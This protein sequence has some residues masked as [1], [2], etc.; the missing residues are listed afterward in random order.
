MTEEL[1]DMMKTTLY[2]RRVDG[3]VKVW[4]TWLRGTTIVTRWGQQGGK[5]SETS[6]IIKGT[7]RQSARVRAQARFNKRIQNRIRKGYVTHLSN[8]VADV[9]V[10]TLN[11]DNLPRSFAPAKP[12]KQISN[13]EMHR[14][15]T[16]GNLMIQRKRDGMRHFIVCDTQGQVR[17]YSSGKA[18]VT[19]HLRP[20]VKELED[21][22]PPRSILDAELVVT[23]DDYDESDGFREVS[24]IA[25]SNPD[26]ARRQIAAIQ[27]AGHT[28]QLIVFDML[29]WNGKEVWREQYSKRW[30]RLECLRRNKFVVRMPFLDVKTPDEARALVK[31]RK[32]EGLVVWDLSKSTMVRMNGSPCRVNCWKDKLVCED[33]VIATGYELGK[34]RNREVVGK[35]RI[36]VR[37]PQGLTSYVPMG[38]CGTGLDDKTREDALSWKYPCV[39]QIEYDKRSEKGFRFPVF[40]RKRDDKKVTEVG[41]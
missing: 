4:T 5:M 34:G 32:W 7:K 15:H 39:I 18:D 25:R 33:D 35:L 17:V 9:Q 27:K 6:D 21:R 41:R 2:H 3:S 11:F 30:M 22:L 16:N 38:K 28:V 13:T 20:L 23:L 8:V 29:Y 24:T 36:A 14:I 1:R 26:R 10:A 31:K 19:D 37:G 40:I 12:I